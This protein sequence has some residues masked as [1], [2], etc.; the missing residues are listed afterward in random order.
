MQSINEI[1][2]IL[3]N[4]DVTALSEFIS[5]IILMKEAVLKSWY[6]RQKKK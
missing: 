6:L 5:I 1:K 2:E 3:K 4:T